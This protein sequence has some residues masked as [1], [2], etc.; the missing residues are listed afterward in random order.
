MSGFSGWD[1]SASHDLDRFRSDIVG[2]LRHYASGNLSESVCLRLAGTPDSDLEIRFNHLNSGGEISFSFPRKVGEAQVRYVF[3]SSEM[4]VGGRRSV[5][6]LGDFVIWVRM[7]KI[8]D[9]GI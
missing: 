4:T 6:T 2:Y 8:G 7:M 5:D 3:I 1:S 9:L